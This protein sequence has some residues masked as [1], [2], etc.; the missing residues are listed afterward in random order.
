VFNVGGIL[1]YTNRPKD[2]TDPGIYFTLSQPNAAEADAGQAAADAAKVLT[3]E[4]NL[5]VD[6]L[7][8]SVS[9]EVA[10]VGEAEA[11]QLIVTEQSAELISL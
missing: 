3:A 1:F 8:A 6:G 7:L 2:I 9:D 10:S 5:I 4:E 11:A